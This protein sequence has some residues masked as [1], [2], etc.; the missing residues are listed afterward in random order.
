MSHNIATEAASGRGVVHSYT[1]NEQNWN[2]TMPPPYV[3]ALVELVEQP[4]LRLMTNIV[5]C[6]PGEVAFGQPVRVVFEQHDDVWIPLFEPEP[7]L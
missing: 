5:N 3:I 7:A 4:N 6:D 2:P 1:V